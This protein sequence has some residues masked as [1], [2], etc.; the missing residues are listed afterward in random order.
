MGANRIEEVPVG[1]KNLRRLR[2]LYLGGNRLRSLPAQICEL[3]HLHALI[4]CDNALESIPECICRLRR[5]ECLQLHGNQLT[6]IPYELV[7]LKSLSELSLRDNPLVVRCAN[8]ERE[9]DKN[10]RV[11]FFLSLSPRFVREMS[12]Q[13]SSLLEL[14]AR[15]VTVRG[16]SVGQGDLPA[17][18]HEYLQSSRSC[19]NPS[20]KGVY[21]NTRVSGESILSTVSGKVVFYISSFRWSTSSLWIFAGSTRSPCCSISARPPARPTSRRSARTRSRRKSGGC[22][23]DEQ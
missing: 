13:P 20:C 7:Q 18:L 10:H 4:L 2:V 11:K 9:N 3:H 21:F 17:T 5:L 19:V 15:V 12:F 1:V 16:L 14:A 8:G 6:T 23:W 22:Y